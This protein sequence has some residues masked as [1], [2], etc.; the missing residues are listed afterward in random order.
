MIFSE[1]GSFEQEVPI[2]V[3]PVVNYLKFNGFIDFGVI[4]PGGKK[5][6]SF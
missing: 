6:I 1:E 5:D 4:K 2:N 3:Y